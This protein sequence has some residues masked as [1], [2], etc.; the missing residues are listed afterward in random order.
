M[1]GGL[2]DVAYSLAGAA[3]AEPDHGDRVKQVLA[4]ASEDSCGSSPASIAEGT[5]LCSPS[6]GDGAEADGEPHPSMT[7]DDEEL[8]SQHGWYPV[9]L[10]EG[11]MNASSDSTAARLLTF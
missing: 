5:Q 6:V 1:F 2:V 7:P 10:D 8:R 11:S 4:G 3:S 9:D